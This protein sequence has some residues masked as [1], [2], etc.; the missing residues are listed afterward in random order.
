LVTPKI[1]VQAAGT[2]SY[3]MIT[4]DLW[5]NSMNEQVPHFDSLIR[6][7]E[8]I[9]NDISPEQFFSFLTSKLTHRKLKFLSERLLNLSLSGVEVLQED[10]CVS[11]HFG[12]NSNLKTKDSVVLIKIRIDSRTG[13]F[14]LFTEGL[15]EFMNSCRSSLLR[16]QDEINDMENNTYFY[17]SLIE[18]SKHFFHGIEKVQDES[19]SRMDTE[20]SAAAAVQPRLTFPP[21]STLPILIDCLQLVSACQ[22]TFYEEN[23]V[24]FHPAED[25]ERI[26]FH[27]L[28]NDV[29]YH[30]KNWILFQVKY[31]FHKNIFH[32]KYQ[33]AITEINK[34]E[35]QQMENSSITILK[36]E[37]KNA[38]ERP[39]QLPKHDDNKIKGKNPS[40]FQIRSSTTNLNQNSVINPQHKKEDTSNNKEIFVLYLIVSFKDNNIKAQ[41]NLELDYYLC[42]NEFS[43]KNKMKITILDR[44]VQAIVA[45]EKISFPSF[46]SLPFQLMQLDSWV[47]KKLKLDYIP[48]PLIIKHEALVFQ[49][50]Q[51]DL[52]KK[53]GSKLA[54]LAIVPSNTHFSTDIVCNNQ[55][56]KISFHCEDNA[57]HATFVVKN[58]FRSLMKIE[59]NKLRKDAHHTN[60]GDDNFISF[61]QIRLDL[62]QIINPAKIKDEVYIK[63]FMNQLSLFLLPTSSATSTSSSVGKDGVVV[64]D[65]IQINI[66]KF[67]E[68]LLKKMQVKLSVELSLINCVDILRAVIVFLWGSLM[69]SSNPSSTAVVNNGFQSH[70][71]SELKYCLRPMTITTNEDEIPMILFAVDKIV[72]GHQSAAPPSVS[73]GTSKPAGNNTASL[74]S[75]N[76]QFKQTIG[77]VKIAVADEKASSLVPPLSQKNEL[78]SF[79]YFTFSF[80]DNA[81]LFLDINQNRVNSFPIQNVSIDRITE[82]I[83]SIQ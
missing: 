43:L 61:A 6:S 19:D 46:S 28:L 81:L 51:K 49:L 71:M 47:T 22:E 64:E 35:Q 60:S 21:F 3:P 57:V 32:S 29:S 36:G 37:N 75:T 52:Q 10:E 26:Q 8:L 12:D 25:E 68:L 62:Y 45:Q 4:A 54:H 59:E 16:F 5:V 67:V 33:W 24:R 55:N 31:W 50:Q 18:E 58:T 30:N 44:H 42:K 27:A 20:D 53:F 79:L 15:G 73:P 70:P 41:N 77:G 1:A 23:N 13:K 40:K 34:L 69:I 7:Y 65:K 39:F 78:F 82:M 2:S 9:G 38:E 17:L 83:N 80:E 72:T 74:V 11:F 48:Y 66:I 14:L 63:L 56:E 76:N